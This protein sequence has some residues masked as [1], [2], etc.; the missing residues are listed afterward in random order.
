MKNQRGF[1]RR[2][3]LF[4]GFFV[5]LTLC[6]YYP[7]RQAGFVTDFTSLAKQLQSY[8]FLDIFRNNWGFHAFIPVAYLAYWS[9]YQLVGLTSV[10][11]YVIFA[12]LHA[13]NAFLLFYLVSKI[14]KH[15]RKREIGFFAA[16]LFLLSPFQAEVLVWRVTLHYLVGAFLMF[17]AFGVAVSYLEKADNT[18]LGLY[19]FLA[20]SSLMSKEYAYMLPLILSVWI[21]YFIDFKVQN[22]AWR[23]VK[24][25]VLSWSIIPIYLSLSKWR[26]GE[27]IGHRAQDEAMFGHW[28]DGIVR[29]LGYALK[30]LFNTRHILSTP[31]QVLLQ[32]FLNKNALLLFGLIVLMFL[33][34][35]IR[36]AEHRSKIELLPWLL[37][38]SFA[39]VP[40]LFLYMPSLFFGENDRYGYY[41]SWFLFPGIVLLLYHLRGKIRY[42][43]LSSLLI[44]SLFHLKTIV[45]A[46]SEN[47]QVQR[48]LMEDFRWEDKDYVFVLNMP[49]I[50]RGLYLFRSCGRES[51]LK[52]ALELIA[53]RETKA[54]I[55]DITQY[56]MM[57]L[58]DG[59]I[60]SELGSDR[61]K[62]EHRYWG[63][64]AWRC[65]QGEGDYENE[66][67]A[68]DYIDKGFELQLKNMPP[69]SVLIYQDSLQW[70]VLDSF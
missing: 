12:G 60:I 20:L 37:S 49:N 65:A 51:I 39:L 17:S 70:K 27:W 5:F 34:L 26:I 29:T 16:L 45:A 58:S 62:V 31:N 18:K 63:R 9:V 57:S 67:Y 24:L 38:F 2:Y 53:H 15:P 41:A 23:H 50:Y 14:L 10:G 7:T 3:V 54:I 69:N 59:V 61:Y 32:Q 8:G 30:Y 52:E 48:A 28:L 19:F 11:W 25:F 22:V 46:W 55:M 1:R 40:S 68:V 13:G 35:I 42:V 4:F 47:A 6:V 21:L 43:F 44:M 64:W 33:F 66:Y 36:R 56:N